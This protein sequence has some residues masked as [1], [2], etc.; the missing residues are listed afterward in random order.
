MATTGTKLPGLKP[1]PAKVDKE[2]AGSLKAMQEALAIRLGQ[3]GDPLD[4]A[5]TLRELIDSG[6]AKKLAITLLIQTRD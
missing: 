5:I 6:L 3:L 1:I 2:L 4:R